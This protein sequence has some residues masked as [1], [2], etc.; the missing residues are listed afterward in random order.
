MKTV[1]FTIF[2]FFLATFAVVAE[3]LSYGDDRMD[4]TPPNQE[5]LVLYGDLAEVVDRGHSQ[6]EFGKNVKRA[7]ERLLDMQIKFLA[8]AATDS[9][10]K[11]LVDVF[12]RDMQALIVK[13]A[14]EYEDMTQQ[15]YDDRK[16]ARATWLRQCH[17]EI[18]K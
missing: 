14:T 15:W 11:D 1:L 8:F 13:M 17:P 4:L 7:N 16:A 10:M 3:E 2:S 18:L 5:C 9:R 6:L 12:D